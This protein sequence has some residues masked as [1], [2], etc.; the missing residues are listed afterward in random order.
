MK[1]AEAL[2]ER[3]GLNQR[4]H[5]LRRRLLGNALVQEGLAPSEDPEELM[6][7]FMS[8]IDVRRGLIDRINRTNV[9][10]RLP[11]GTTLA[12]AI[13]TRDALA[14]KRGAYK[15]VA[16]AAAPK[17]DRYS[18]TEI[19]FIGTVNVVEYQKLVDRL[20]RQHRELDT[21]IQ[22]LNWTTDLVE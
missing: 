9:V 12:A 19:R 7:E 17:Q 6:A 20:S 13:T 16:D 18:K 1:L 11:D 14:L 15:D 2:I 21:I 5:E 22:G 8:L 3:A 10:T 4:Y